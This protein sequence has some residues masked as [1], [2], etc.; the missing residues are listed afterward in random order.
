MNVDGDE[1]LAIHS[2]MLDNKQMLRQ[3][4]TEFHHLFHRLD[5]R[6]FSA[7]GIRVEVG[8]GVVPIK[9]SYSDVLATDIVPGPGL[10]RVINA[11]DM[12][13]DDGSVRVV[14]GQNCFH[15]FP[16]PELFFL[17]LERV[18][19]PGGGVILLEPY[20]GPFASFLYKQLFKTEG[21]DKNFPSWETPVIGPMNGANQALSY[22]VFVRDK[23]E[24]QQKFPTLKIV[25]TEPCANYLKYLVSGGLNFRQ[26]CPDWAIPILSLAQGILSP[27]NCWLAL[28]HVIVLR[29]EKA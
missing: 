21:F 23:H 15:H 8:A 9:G 16:R 22:I 6:F 5:N 12:D 18:L 10:D 24:F 17:E 19:S 26:L 7:K 25:H 4:F 11:E 3:V 20:Y 27:F 14:F 2:M 13:L 1:R 28:H 29:K